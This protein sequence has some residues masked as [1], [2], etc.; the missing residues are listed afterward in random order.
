MTTQT[1]R[2]Y[3]VSAILIALIVGW[4]VMGHFPNIAPTAAAA[5]FAA[6]YL[7]SWRHALIIPILGMLISDFFLGS[8]N[9][10]VTI[11]VYVGLSAPVFL[12][13][14][15]K[16]NKNS[17]ASI[18]KKLGRVATVV[19]LGSTF[20]F[21]ISNLAEWM[22]GSLYALTWEGLVACYVAAIPFYQYTLL[23]DMGF[24]MAIFGLYYLLADYQ[25]EKPGRGKLQPKPIRIRSNNK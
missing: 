22:F 13:G 21:V 2:N 8:Y 14:M 7:R 17:T 12:S 1:K 15:I 16:E 19:P 11:S 20:F 25:E 10:G 5:L 6:F 4:R 18:F 23:G 9:L 24:A 3:L